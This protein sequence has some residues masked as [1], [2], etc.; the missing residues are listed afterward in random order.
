MRA[1]IIGNGTIGDYE[2]IRSLICGD[3][4]VICADGGLRHARAMD[5]TLIS[6]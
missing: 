2:Y 4:V 3:D 6:Q 5:I 1:V